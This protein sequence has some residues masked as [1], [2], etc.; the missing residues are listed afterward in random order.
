M[1]ALAWVLLAAV[2]V[3][4]APG[5]DVHGTYRLQG[6][7]RVDARPFPAADQE[8]R[9]DAVLS[10]G[11]GAHAVRIHLAGQGLTCDLAA[12]LDA[13]GALALAQGQRC[14]ADLRSEETEGRVEARL[15]SGSGTL[16]DEV[17]ELALDFALSG[18]VRLRPG[19][20]LDALRQVLP[21][22]GTRGEPVPVRGQAHG[23]AQGRR[24]HSRAAD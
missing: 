9:A 4:A 11:A 24:D 19:A 22:P 5:P 6:R 16:R 13:V 14:T 3:T 7:A 20:T 15:V 2:A 8:V 12:T 21:L 18:W 10:P 17:L 23:R 1:A